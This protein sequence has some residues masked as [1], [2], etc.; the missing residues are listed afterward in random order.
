MSTLSA[1]GTRSFTVF[2]L[3]VAAVVVDPAV[4]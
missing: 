1:S 4:A 3:I 2:G